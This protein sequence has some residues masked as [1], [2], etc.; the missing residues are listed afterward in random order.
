[1]RAAHGGGAAAPGVVSPE[2]RRHKQKRL[3]GHQTRRE[4]LLQG[5]GEKANL[6]GLQGGGSGD[7]QE[8]PEPAADDSE[9]HKTGDGTR[10]LECEQKRRRWP[11]YLAAMLCVRSWRRG[12][13]G[14]GDQARVALWEEEIGTPRRGLVRWRPK[15]GRA[16]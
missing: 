6:T 8:P 4:K 10:H 12:G 11:P 16:P 1:V 13:S 9:W 14:H 15:T 7:G 5:G 3:P 2:V